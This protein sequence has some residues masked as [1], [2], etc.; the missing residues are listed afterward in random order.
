[1]AEKVTT[2]S[3]KEVNQLQKDMEKVESKL[4][5][6]IELLRSEIRLEILKGFEGLRTELTKNSQNIGGS[7]GEVVSRKSLAEPVEMGSLGNLPRIGVGSS[8]IVGAFVMDKQPG[9]TTM[10]SQSTLWDLL[11]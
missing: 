9:M 2:R 6:M 1:M 5:G 11:R 7:M 10:G 4:D 3:Q 8:R